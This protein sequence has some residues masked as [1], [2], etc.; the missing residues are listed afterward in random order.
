MFRLSN[1]WAFDMLTLI[2]LS[3]NIPSIESDVK[4]CRMKNMEI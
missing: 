2:Y 3:S 4:I 1:G